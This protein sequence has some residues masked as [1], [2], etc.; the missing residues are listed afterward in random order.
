[1]DECMNN[2]ITYLKKTFEKNTIFVR[3]NT[4]LNLEVILF[5]NSV[6]YILS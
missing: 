1:M 2:Q 4:T 5:I 3:T 6:K